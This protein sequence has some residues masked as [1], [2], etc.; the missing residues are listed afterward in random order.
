M[1]VEPSRV[2]GQSKYNMGTNITSFRNLAKDSNQK[3]T[4]QSDETLIELSSILWF[5]YDIRIND[6]GFLSVTDLINA[7]LSSNN[8]HGF[9]TVRV[10]D[11]FRKD[12]FLRNL[13]YLLLKKNRVFYYSFNEFFE[14]VK[15]KKC[16]KILKDMNLYQC[17]GKGKN[18]VVFC[19]KDIWILLAIEFTPRIIV[20]FIFDYDNINNLINKYVYPDEFDISFND[21]YNRSKEVITY[22]A[23][24]NQ[25]NA[26]KIGKTTNLNLRESAMRNSNY[27]LSIIAY[28][29]GD[30]EDELHKLYKHKHIKREWFSLSKKD[31]FD[32]MNNYGFIVR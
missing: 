32:I 6:N 24:D 29:N 14:I 22:L 26:I 13:Y 2:G 18:R 21:R 20:D 28:F 8:I 31:V 1:S 12:S 23:K 15:K 4:L 9:C 16:V 7:V 30:I 27:D 25:H 17:I 11:I 10:N 5:G 19:D 3:T